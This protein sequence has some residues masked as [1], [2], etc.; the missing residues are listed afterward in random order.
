MWNRTENTPFE[1]Y[2]IYYPFGM[3]FVSSEIKR[4]ERILG[5]VNA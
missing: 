3:E 5:I 1:E 2:W 4:L